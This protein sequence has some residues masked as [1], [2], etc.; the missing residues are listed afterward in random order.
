MSSFCVD[1]CICHQIRFSTLKLLA[2][3]ESITDFH[4]L[5]KK[6]LFGKGC[7]MCRVYVEDMLRTGKCEFDQPILRPDP[8]LAALQIKGDPHNQ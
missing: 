4:E 5:F 8:V 6:D 2:Q 1:R 7:G 3:E